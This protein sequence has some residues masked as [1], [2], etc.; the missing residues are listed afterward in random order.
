MYRFVNFGAHNNTLNS[1]FIEI[2]KT[3]SCEKCQNSKITDIK[4]HKMAHLV[5]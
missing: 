4:V 5:S 2:L 3:V 1:T